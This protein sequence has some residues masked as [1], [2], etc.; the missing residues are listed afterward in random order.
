MKRLGQLFCSSAEEDGILT[1][2][3]ELDMPA[4]VTVPAAASRAIAI[5]EKDFIVLVE[6]CSVRCRKET[7]RFGK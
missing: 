6:R 5:R 7:R 2:H 3:S 1:A 4:A